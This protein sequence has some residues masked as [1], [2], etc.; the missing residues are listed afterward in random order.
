MTL[1]TSLPLSGEKGSNTSSQTCSLCETGISHLRGC[2]GK[3]AGEQHASIM[4]IFLNGVSMERGKTG[5]AAETCAAKGMD[6]AG[7]RAET[8]VS[9][10][11]DC[12]GTCAV[13]FLLPKK[14][15][16]QIVMEM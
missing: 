1:N 8:E 2:F 9:E 3:L 14:C 6:A 12:S 13:C 4:I 16:E 5:L 15:R 10:R 11:V 7:L